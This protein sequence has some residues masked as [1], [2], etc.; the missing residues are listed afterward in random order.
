MSS[1]RC[2]TLR[3]PWR[4]GVFCLVI[5]AL[6]GTIIGTNVLAQTAP[7]TSTPTATLEDL[8]KSQNA[9]A[10][11]A[12]NA[13]PAVVFIKVDK[14][15]DRDVSMSSPFGS[16]SPFDQFNNDFFER[17]FRNRQPQ[18]SPDQR[19]SPRQKFHQEG[20]GTGFIINS[21]GYILTNNHM[22]DGVDRIRVTLADGRQFTAKSIGT[23]PQSDLGVIKIEASNLPVLPLGD[24]NQIEV[25]DWAIAIGNPFG[26]SQ[27]LTVGVISA[28][29]RNN[30]G[31]ADYE[32]FIQTDAA[33]NP[34]NSGGPLLNLK[35]E[36]VGVNTAIFSRSGGYMGIGFAIPINMAKDVYDQLLKHGSVTR[37]Y[38]G[39]YIQEITPELAESFGLKE[40]EG[41]LVADVSKDSPAEKSG[42]QRGDIILELEGKPVENVGHFR[43]QIAM[44][45]PGDSASLTLIRNHDRIH[46]SVTTGKLPD[47]NSESG[48]SDSAA[49]ANLGFSVQELTP[50]VAEHLS[51]EG[52]S[53]V[54]ISDVDDGSPAALAGLQPGTMIVEMNRTPVKSMSDFKNISR[55]AIQEGRV[56][57]LVRDNKASHFIAFRLDQ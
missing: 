40:N 24:S 47:E 14:V 27:T 28:K 16:N 57:L 12:K 36:A 13:A 51:L 53:G 5:L 52:E 26:L 1:V 10:Q 56:L 48:V 38:L 31:I 21:D 3:S 41:I 45:P 34:G 25:G 19:S 9:F 46:L 32:D 44:I 49:P 50:D 42:L 7:T 17:F 37:G 23:D 4:F 8:A 6:I 39:V 43:N 54:V 55:K 33:I 29:G 22:V 2:L 15:M 11:I 20:Q 18:R 30:V 35:G